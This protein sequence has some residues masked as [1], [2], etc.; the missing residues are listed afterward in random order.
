MSDDLTPP[1]D[2]LTSKQIEKLNLEIESLRKK[3]KWELYL[4]LVPLVSALVLAL[5][6][7]LNVLQFL[8]TQ[9]KE[10]AAREMGERTRVLSQINSDQN[11]IF[12]FARDETLPLSSASFLFADLQRAMA[13]PF[14]NDLEYRR[15]FTNNLFL[16]IEELD[17]NSNPRGLAFALL[18]LD[19]WADYKPYL[20]ENPQKFDLVLNAYVRGLSS[21]SN[22]Y[23]EYIDGIRCGKNQC[24]PLEN[25][26]VKGLWSQFLDTVAGFKKHVELIADD[27]KNTRLEDI[28]RKQVEA[29]AHVMKREDLIKHFLGPVFIEAKG[30][31]QQPNHKQ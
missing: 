2:L 11:E 13:S 18:T 10:Q 7:M 17:R 21:I 25:D 1:K 28:K 12:K 20:R 23:P 8:S 26:D 5:S 22:K 16:L 3:I 9:Q 24:K 29:F 14:I 6:L 30:P 27:P 15:P 31:E 4:Q 19:H